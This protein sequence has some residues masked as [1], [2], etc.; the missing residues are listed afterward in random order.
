M[1]LH[2]DLLDVLVCPGCKGDLRPAAGQGAAAGLVGLDCG[3]CGLR[4]PIVDDIPV[5]LLD[6]AERLPASN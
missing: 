4:F 3:R 6:Q 2:K 5:M 1:A